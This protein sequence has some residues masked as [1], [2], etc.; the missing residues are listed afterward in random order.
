MKAWGFEYKTN[1]VWTK[2][3]HTAGFYIYGKHELLLI[4]VKGSKMLPEIKYKSIIEGSN[5]IHSKK[6]LSSL[7]LQKNR[8]L[9]LHR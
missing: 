7:V 5:K 9:L 3:N 8:L 4:G 6:P 2:K 1:I